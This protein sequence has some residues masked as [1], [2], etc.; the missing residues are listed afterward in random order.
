MEFQ[1][2]KIVFLLTIG[3]CLI[4]ATNALGV[5]WDEKPKSPGDIPAYPNSLYSKTTNLIVNS[6]PV[7][8]EIYETKDTVKEAYSTVRKNLV[9]TGYKEIYSSGNSLTF[10]KNKDNIVVQF[11]HNKESISTI[12]IFYKA[13]ST[14]CIS[15]VSLDN[16]GNNL[17]NIPK[18]PQS[19]R[20]LSIERLDTIKAC[21]AIYKTSSSSENISSFYKTVMKQNGWQTINMPKQSDIAGDVLYFESNS[22]WCCVFIEKEKENNFIIIVQYKKD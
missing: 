11:F 22:G 2:N 21:S 16:P 1:K 19:V 12:I 8:C 5:I 6:Q 4:I 18:Y 20:I 3:S 14:A 7:L 13:E 15:S 10:K 9:L 17:E